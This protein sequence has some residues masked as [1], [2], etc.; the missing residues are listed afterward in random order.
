MRAAHALV[1]APAAGVAAGGAGG[2]G[3]VR[4]MPVR[5]SSSGRS[6]ARRMMCWRHHANAPTYRMYSHR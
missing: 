2:R 6:G 4:G 5:R 3:A 1:A